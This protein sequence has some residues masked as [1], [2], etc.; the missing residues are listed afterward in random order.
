ME[1]LIMGEAWTNEE[2]E[3]LKDNYQYKTNKELSILLNRTKP[4]I[5]LKI[6]RLGLSKSKYSFNHDYFEEINTPEKAY[7]L[8]FIYADGGVSDHELS[9]KLQISDKEH[10]KKF[11]KAINGNFQIATFD[12]VCNLNG[13]TYGGCQIRVYST[14]LVRDLQKLGVYQNKSLTI[15]FPKIN[16]L[17]KSHFIR[18]FFD[19]DGC[20]TQSNHNNGKSYIRADFT[21]GSECFTNQLRAELYS[22][23]INSYISKPDG[24]PFRLM[25][26]GMKNC[27]VFF[28]YIYKDADSTIYLDRKYKKK[29]SL[30]RSLNIEQRLLL[31][32]EMDDNKRL[33]RERIL[34]S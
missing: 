6:N 30:Y 1:E 7:W 34:E 20:L 10:L 19:G 21:C 23:N 13:K 9:I 32:S 26:G 14:K 12:R 5:D 27:D 28:N 25:I 3:F 2:L 4:A 31:R 17:L 33:K 15:V 11:N 24:K 16:D 29:N 18:G 8:G 22:I